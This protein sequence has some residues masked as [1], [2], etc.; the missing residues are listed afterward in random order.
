MEQNPVIEIKYDRQ[1]NED[2]IGFQQWLMDLHVVN[3]RAFYFK[4]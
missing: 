4:Q 2:K 1:S 3:S